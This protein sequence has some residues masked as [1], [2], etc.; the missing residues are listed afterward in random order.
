MKA[1]DA[2]PAPGTPTASEVKSSK[3]AV[4]AISRRA[5]QPSKPDAVA[6]PSPA[7]EVQSPAD[8]VKVRGHITAPP[9]LETA[10]A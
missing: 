8:L 2:I 7:A 4:V 3:P 5:R 1:S 6:S 9:L 10:L